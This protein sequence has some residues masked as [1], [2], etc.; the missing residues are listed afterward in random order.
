MSTAGPNAPG[1]MASDNSVGTA[2]WA[3]PDNAKTSDDTR[4]YAQA[5]AG[6]IEYSYYLKATNFGFAIPTGATIDG[7]SVSFERYGHNTGEQQYVR[8]AIIKLV[9]NDTVSG[10]N[11]AATSTRWPNTEG[12]YTYGGASDLWG[13]TLTASDV[14][15]N[16]FGAVLQV[17]ITNNT[18][19][20][21]A[22]GYVDFMSITV[23]YTESGGG[24]SAVP[25]IMNQYRQRQA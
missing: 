5:L 1:T 17:V 11:K 23:T 18:K 22:R 16:N 6:T 9:K 19:M 24:A 14:N 10:D 8:D 13:N 3:L 4:T 2:T 25:V 12:V 20:S 21:I 7:I 15:A